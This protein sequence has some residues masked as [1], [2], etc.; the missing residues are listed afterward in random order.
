MLPDYE[1]FYL[2]GINSM[3]GFDWRG[4]SAFDADGREVGGEQSVL[5]NA[6]M[7]FPL[8]RQ[9]GLMGVLFHDTGDVYRSGD[10]IEPDNLRRSAGYGIRWY[11]PM[12]PIRL[13][14]GHILDRR[15]GE[16]S[17]RWEFS[18]GGMF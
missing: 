11:S 13:E 2:G 12:G 17:G 4:I 9:A 1:K 8:V 18:I 5:F 3:R 7:I 10:S 15:E 14:R 6:E 16:P